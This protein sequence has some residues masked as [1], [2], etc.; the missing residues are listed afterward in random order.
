MKWFLSVLFM[1]VIPSLHAEVTPKHVESMLD[2][3]VRENVISK[4]EADKARTRMKNLTPKQW[5]DINQQTAIMAERSPAS[6]TPSNN[7]I[8]EVNNIDLDGAQFKTIE[9]EIKRII[10]EYREVR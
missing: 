7:K 8:E 6:V 5:S 9:N 3:M 1:L 4:E 10:P 2:Q